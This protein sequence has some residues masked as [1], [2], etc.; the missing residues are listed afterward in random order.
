MGQVQLQQLADGGIGVDHEDVS[1]HAA[2]L[3][4]YLY[5]KYLYT[6]FNMHEARLTEQYDF[7]K[8]FRAFSNK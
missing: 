5:D 3:N 6:D 2:I 7:F 1:G 4:L 8:A